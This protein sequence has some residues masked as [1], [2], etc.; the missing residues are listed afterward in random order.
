MKVALLL[1][2]LSADITPVHTC[3]CSSDVLTITLELGDADDDEDE[4]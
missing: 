3:I 4:P 1:A 2:L